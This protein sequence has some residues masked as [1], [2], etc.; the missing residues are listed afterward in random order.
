MS[1]QFIREDPATALR[2]LA[3]LAC[4]RENLP[5]YEIPPKLAPRLAGLALRG[6]VQVSPTLPPPPKANG[7]KLEA[8]QGLLI[9]QLPPPPPLPDIDYDPLKQAS[10]CRA[11]LLEIIRRAAYDWV[12]YRLSSDLANKR[13][14]EDAFEWLFVESHESK[15]AR[16]RVTSDKTLTSFLSIC[17]MMDMDPE[18]VRDRIRML[19]VKNVMSV[20]RP[21]EKRHPPAEEC[22][23][24]EHPVHLSMDMMNAIDQAAT[25][26]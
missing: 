2:A 4:L 8:I 22:G 9:P 3:A 16:E 19:T 6:F 14:A 15:A 5:D 17:E 21:A 24:N 12:L 11:L 7:H 26:Q 20:G 25:A 1:L 10:C 23:F 13:L 18:K